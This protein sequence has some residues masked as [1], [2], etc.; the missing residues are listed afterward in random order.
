M[1]WGEGEARFSAAGAMGRRAVGSDVIPVRIAGVGAGRTT[2]G[3]RFARPGADRAGGAF[4]LDRTDFTSAFVLPDVEARRD[5]VRQIGD[6]GGGGDRRPRRRRWGH[7]GDRRPSRG[8]SDGDRR[9]LRRLL[10][11]P[12]ARGGG[13]AH[14]ASSDVLRR[15]VGGRPPHAPFFVARCPIRRA[16]I[17]RRSDAATSGL[18]GAPGGRGLLLP[19][20]SQAQPGGPSPAARGHG[21]PGEAGHAPREDRAARGPG[22]ACGPETRARA[23]SSASPGRAPCEDRSRVGYGA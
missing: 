1:R 6:R 2:Y 18:S 3:H 23:R 22:R 21:V 16:R 17:P 8:V 10:S 4:G 14:P 20:R 12:A 11:R 5:A 7:A 9:Q 15:G 13:D 19:R